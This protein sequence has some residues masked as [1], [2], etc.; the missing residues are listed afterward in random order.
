M[1][2]VLRLVVLLVALLFGYSAYRQYIYD[3]GDRTREGKT[4]LTGKNGGAIKTEIT[5]INYM[6]KPTRLSMTLRLIR[7]SLAV[8]LEEG[9]AGG[10]VKTS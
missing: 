3:T 2:Q 1:V 9:R 5:G 6:L 10:C 8:E 4:E 7:C